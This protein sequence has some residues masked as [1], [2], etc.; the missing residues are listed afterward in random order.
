MLWHP[1]L[2]T[3]GHSLPSG[4]TGL[5]IHVLRLFIMLGPNVCHLFQG[6]CPLCRYHANLQLVSL[7]LQGM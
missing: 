3:F 5:G 2:A 1:L 6:R 7:Q 4:Q